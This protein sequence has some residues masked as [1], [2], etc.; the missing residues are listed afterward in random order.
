MDETLNRLKSFRCPKPFL[1]ADIIY[2]W[3]HRERAS[4]IREMKPDD[5]IH[6]SRKPMA[7][8]FRRE[9]LTILLRP[10]LADTVDARGVALTN[11]FLHSEE[12]R[13]TMQMRTTGRDVIYL[14]VLILRYCDCV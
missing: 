4:R 12:L 2:E 10:R 5:A 13:L 7:G 8:P 3:D 11:G 9:E 1:L 14:V 6:P